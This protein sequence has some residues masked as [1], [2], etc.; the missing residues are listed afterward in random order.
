[1]DDQ[2]ERKETKNGYLA[3]RKEIIMDDQAERIGKNDG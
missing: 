3:K 1:M 2:A